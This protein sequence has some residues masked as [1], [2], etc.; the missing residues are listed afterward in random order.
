VIL[1]MLLGTQTNPNGIQHLIDLYR[2]FLHVAVEHKK[3]NF[4]DF[5]VTLKM[6]GF[7]FRVTLRLYRT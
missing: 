1:E 5:C 2:L 7:E 3:S 6:T 4:D